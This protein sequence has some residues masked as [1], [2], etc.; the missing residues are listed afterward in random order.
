MIKPKTEDDQAKPVM[1]SSICIGTDMM[2]SDESD[3]PADLDRV[4]Q[5]IESKAS[6]V[7][8]AIVDVNEG[9]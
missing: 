2:S 4:G 7:D 6:L 9:T 1:M 8:A 3:E 5:V